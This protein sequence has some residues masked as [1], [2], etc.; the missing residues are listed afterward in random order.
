MVRF[1]FEKE[2]KVVIDWNKVDK[3]I[4][5]L[6]WKEV[7]LKMWKL[8]KNA[9]TDQI[10]YREVYMKGIAVSYYYEGYNIFKSE[11]L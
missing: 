9:L 2:L 6:L 5:C 3:E 10:D 1:S 7:Q 8:R 4:T 11:E